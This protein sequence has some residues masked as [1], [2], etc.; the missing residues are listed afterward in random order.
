VVGGAVVGGA[1]VGGVVVAG[2]TVVAGAAVVTGTVVGA[3]VVVGDPELVVVVTPS[4]PAPA[5]AYVSFV[6]PPRNE[7]AVSET[8]AMNPTSRAYSTRPA[9][10]S[11]PRC[12]SMAS[13]LP[14][15]RHGT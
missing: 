1:V 7:S 6:R 12:V 9:P 8:M 10:L 5:F 11:P 14:E 2:A 13:L 4:I 15:R 3:A